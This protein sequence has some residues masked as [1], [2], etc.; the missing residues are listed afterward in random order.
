MQVFVEIVGDWKTIIRSL[1]DV[2]WGWI[3]RS[4]VIRRDLLSAASAWYLT[5]EL[6]LLQEHWEDTS[7]LFMLLMLFLPV[8][9]WSCFVALGF[10][11]LDFRLVGDWNTA[12]LIDIATVVS[13]FPIQTP[14]HIFLYDYQSIPSCS[15][16]CPGEVAVCLWPWLSCPCSSGL[17]ETRTPEDHESHVCV[18]VVCS[19]HCDTYIRIYLYGHDPASSHRV[20]RLL[21]CDHDCHVCVPQSDGRLLKTNQMIPSVN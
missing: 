19:Y 3:E 13:H 9:W 12:F 16:L 10:M 1:T 4:R 20:Q 8:L 15:T 2:L 6:H 18:C 11:Y 14:I 7:A 5:S 21:L 17:W